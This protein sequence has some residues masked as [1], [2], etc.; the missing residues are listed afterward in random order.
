MAAIYDMTTGNTIVEG[1]QGCNACDEAIQAAAVI[2][3]DLG[4]DVLLADDDGEWIVHPAID[5]TR[6]AATSRT[7]R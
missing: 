5:G 3:D 1:L 4:R 2:A 6:E 7:E